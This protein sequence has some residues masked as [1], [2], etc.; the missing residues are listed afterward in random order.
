MDG[1]N[2]RRAN[3]GAGVQPQPQFINPVTEIAG[4]IFFSIG[5]I[6]ATVP[7]WSYF[8]AIAV[9]N[10]LLIAIGGIAFCALGIKLLLENVAPPL[11]QQPAHQ[12]P[13]HHRQRSLSLGDLS[14]LDDGSGQLPDTPTESPARKQ[15]R[16]KGSAG[17]ISKMSF[18]PSIDFSAQ[19]QSHASKLQEAEDERAVNQTLSQTLQEAQ[20]QFNHEPKEG[21]F[22]IPILDPFD[23]LYS[24]ATNEPHHGC[25]VGMASLD[26]PILPETLFCEKIRFKNS[27]SNDPP[28]D[29]TTKSFECSV[30]TLL[31]A[32]GRPDAM[33]FVEENFVSILKTEL[34]SRRLTVRGIYNSLQSA[35]AK[36]DIL[37]FTQRIKD[38]TS[39]LVA[40]FLG[41]RLWVANIGKNRAFFFSQEVLVDF[42]E[43]LFADSPQT[44]RKAKPDLAPVDTPQRDAPPAEKEEEEDADFK[45][46]EAEK[47]AQKKPFPLPQALCSEMNTAERVFPDAEELEEDGPAF[48]IKPITKKR[49][50]IGGATRTPK[51]VWGAA[52][53]TCIKLQTEG[54]LVFCS[55]GLNK[56]YA[57]YT[58]IGKYLVQNSGASMEDLAIG[59]V[60][61]AYQAGSFL[62]IT[63]I[64]AQ[65]TQETLRI[66]QANKKD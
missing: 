37:C 23:D 13:R 56:L 11:P 57:P 58:Q 20:D 18:S 43:C 4:Q 8:A 17:D 9:P 41:S 26:H 27:L 52:Q 19:F 48:K 45:V 39:L 10:P 29:S 46:M 44:P 1:V 65:I 25:S 47:P 3:G 14:G 21:L 60:Q 34:E 7:I 36:L 31:T 55:F 2:V 30:L 5:M 62:N 53:I 49:V 59:L 32:A 16:R 33:L 35:I 38:G 64:V 66:A 50:I 42:Q 40:L 28:S 12:R 51:R 63:A 6:F 15:H 61:K 22:D 24:A 54:I